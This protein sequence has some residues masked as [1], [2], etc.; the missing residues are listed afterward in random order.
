MIKFNTPILLLTYKKIITLKKV[1][2]SIKQIKPIK[3]YIYSD[4]PKNNDIQ[5][6]D[7]IKDVRSL[8]DNFNFNCKVLKKYNNQNLGLRKAVI[9]AINWFFENEKMGIILEDDCLP[10]RSFYFFCQDNLKYHYN[11]KQIMNIGGTNLLSG[12]R[13]LDY[14]EK[15]YSYFFT[16]SPSI[17]GWATWRDRWKYFDEKMKD[18]SKFRISN[19]KRKELF[20][21][22]FSEKFFCE[23]IDAV[24]QKK[25]PSWAYTWD[26]SIRT[27]NGLNITPKKNLVKNIGSTESPTHKNEMFKFF[28]N[29]KKFKLK[30]I[31]HPETIQN[32]KD[33][34]QILSQMFLRRGFKQIA[35]L[36]IRSLFINK[37]YNIKKTK[38]YFL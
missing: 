12:V 30:N 28:F 10:H 14:C 2:K 25:D 7:K 32:N 23:R 36:I 33:A 17:W 38:K 1:I 9:S 19:I 5:E 31:K 29:L 11:N 37:F 18:W 4:G 15:N 34:D 3:L 22:K 6:I 8:L 35:F 13:N 24:Y 21:D 20:Q 27:R 16:K 26:Y